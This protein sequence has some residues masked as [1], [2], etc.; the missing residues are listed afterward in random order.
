MTVKLKQIDL[1]AGTSTTAV[2]DGQSLTGDEAAE[3]IA[4]RDGANRG[5]FVAVEAD[6][7][8]Q[9]SDAGQSL[10]VDGA[11]AVTSS[12]LPTGAAT[13]ATLA[14][15][16]SESTFTARTPTLGAKT[17]AGSTPV[18]LATDQPA[19]TANLGTTG[20]L[21]L[22]ATLTGGTQ[23]A[24]A[25][26]G[27]KGTTVAADLTSTASGANHQAL[28]VAIL[29]ASGN[30]ITA[31][32]GGTQ[33]ADGVVRGTATGSLMM[34]D[35][36]TNIQS[37]S[38]DS[39]GRQNVN[40]RVTDG[41]NTAAVKP[42]S[43]APAASDPALVVA[44]SPNSTVAVTASALPLPAGAATETT[45][46]SRLSEA[47]FSARTPTLGPKT[48]A[49]STPVVLASD[50]P[51]VPIADGGGSITVDT[52]QLPAG[53][54]NGRLNTNL[55]SWFGSTTPTIGQKP[56]TGSLPVTLAS[57]QSSVAVAGSVD[58]TSVIPGVAATNL[59]KAVNSTAGA[60]DTGVAALGVYTPDTQGV[61]TVNAG[62]YATLNIDDKGRL[63][64][65]PG[66]WV[67]IDGF[68]DITGFTGIDTDTTNIQ[69]STNHVRGTH[70]VQFD[71]VNSPANNTLGMIQRAIPAINLTNLTTG[72]TYLQANVFLPSVA[73]VSAVVFRIGTDA[74]NYNS[75]RIPLQ[76]SSPTAGK[77][78]IYRAAVGSSDASVGAGWDVSAITYVAAGV[79]LSGTNATLSGVVFDTLVATG[80]QVNS[81]DTTTEI[82][83]S[84][85]S[86]KIDLTKIAGNNI[87]VNSGVA[88]SSTQRVA[89]ATDDPN[90][91]AIN[92]TAQTLLTESTFTG[93]T[94]TLGQKTSTASSPVVIA[95]DQSTLP[96]S[97]TVTANIGS[98]NGLALNATLTDGSQTSIVRSGLKGSTLPAAV[99]S[100]AAGT[101]HQ[102]LDV[103]IVDA[104]GNQIT[105]FG[106]GSSTAPNATMTTIT[107]SG[108]SQVF[109]AANTSRKGATIWN[110]GAYGLF[111]LLGTGSAS[112]TN[113][114]LTM[115]PDT[116]YEMPF[117]Y[118][119]Q[120]SGAWSGGG[121]VARITELS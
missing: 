49:G 93:R 50:Q 72:A 39:A 104:A 62:D 5:Q 110:G 97:G 33:Y 10:T 70:A 19:I 44:V 46:A 48:S 66:A 61:S 77:W 31:F 30:Q 108:V 92:A 71:I 83:T 14:T 13:E 107:A 121:G 111:L 18:V 102:A 88:T 7:R 65:S 52:D 75:W 117:G 113:Y 59:G 85:S 81:S 119:G 76:G 98:I 37:A 32:G 47:T 43:T 45:L 73:N 42:A 15:R 114:T 22:D 36:G 74:S 26:A 80:G 67:I 109:L 6:G 101:N 58:V 69:Q 17:S 96:V 29:D 103:A 112:V 86:N 16:V 120:I 63:R 118:T 106:G 57:D 38:G 2:T 90:L 60:T 9:V 24:I 3:L 25:R 105:S 56:M 99:T 12:T 79:E 21:A 82:T 54:V 11:V 40:S 20:G 116:Y 51:A 1:P 27:S 53:L 4:G 89:I 94:P 95:S 68:D 41:T 91:S 115:L 28:D 64:V 35:D 34:V 87:E 78:Q 55:G 84:V 8:V 23:K 100:T